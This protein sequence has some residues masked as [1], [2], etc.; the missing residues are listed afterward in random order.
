M[1][2]MNI[3]SFSGRSKMASDYDALLFCYAGVFFPMM[4]GVWYCGGPDDFFD[5]I[6]GGFHTVWDWVSGILT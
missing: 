2:L 4:V 5:M 1:R 3:T 6:V